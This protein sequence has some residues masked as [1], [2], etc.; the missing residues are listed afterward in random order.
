MTETSQLFVG[1]DLGGT[2]CKIGIGTATG[3]LVCHASLPTESHRGPDDVLLR[4]GQ[5]VL[6]LVADHQVNISTVGMGIPGLVDLKVGATK[7]LPNFPG[8]WRDVAVAKILGD[9]LQVPV[10]LANDARVATLGELRFGHGQNL[11]RPTL[12]FFTL[13]TGVGGG[14]AIDGQLRLGSLGAAGELGHQTILMDGPQC[15]CGNRGCLEAI[16]SAGAIVSEGIRLMKSGLAPHLHERVS[17]DVNKVTVEVMMEVRQQDQQILNALND[18]T[19]Y[20]GIATANAVTIL[21]PDLVVFGGGV[22]EMGDF[23]LD[24]V[25][26]VVTKRVGMFPTDGVQIL[27]SELGNLAGVMGAIALASESFH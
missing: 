6:S 24:R 19:T 2:A 25:R 26:D 11:K 1:I 12:A 14:I 23:L 17:G 22:A 16:A 13:G 27:H 18:V 20:I 3:E 5:F 10:R 9:Q 15:G 7:F 21:H 4:I 8:Q